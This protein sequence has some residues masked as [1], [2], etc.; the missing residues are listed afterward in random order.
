[1]RREILKY[2]AKILVL[3]FVLSRPV[4][5]A[6]GYFNRSGEKFGRG[7][8][9]I[10]FSGLEIPKSIEEGIENDQ[11]YKTVLVNPVHGVFSMLGRVL[12]GAYEVTTFWIPQR[13]I[14]KPPYVMPGIRDYLKEKYDA[15]GDSPT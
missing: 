10:A 13:P 14:L 4:W 5:S 7:V 8:V 12:V 3:S 15:E 9:N 6:D 1:M 2:V 11:P